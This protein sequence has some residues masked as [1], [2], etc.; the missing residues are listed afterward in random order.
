[1]LVSELEKKADAMMSKKRANTK[2][3]VDMSSN[4]VVP[5]EVW[6]TLKKEPDKLSSS[7]CES[8]K[9]IY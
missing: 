2:V 6:I 4:Y 7:D 1:M 9:F 3:P 8:L 5:E